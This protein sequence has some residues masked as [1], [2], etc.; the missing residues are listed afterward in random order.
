M[1]KK[2]DNSCSA[3]YVVLALVCVVILMGTFR[4]EAVEGLK[5]LGTCLG[6]SAVGFLLFVAYGTVASRPSEPRL[7]TTSQYYPVR[8]IPEGKIGETNDPEDGE[9]HKPEWQELTS[10]VYLLLSVKNFGV[11]LR[12]IPKRYTW[13]FIRADN[14]SIYQVLSSGR[15]APILIPNGYPHLSYMLFPRGGDVRLG[16]RVEQT[17]PL[18]TYPSTLHMEIVLIYDTILEEDDLTHSYRGDRELRV[19]LTVLDQDGHE[20]DGMTRKL[21]HEMYEYMNPPDTSYDDYGYDR[22]RP[23]WH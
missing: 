17:G 20:D 5:V 15:S 4:Q 10:P 8:C 19:K 1:E 13:E 16:R 7:E 9:H 6:C 23:P 12:P 22:H 18:S 14:E 21:Y 2:S 3:V 11:S